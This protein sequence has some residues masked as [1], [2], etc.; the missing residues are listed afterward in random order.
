MS[1]IQ[2][3]SE[4]LSGHMS[5]ELTT[6]GLTIAKECASSGLHTFVNSH[7]GPAG[8]LQRN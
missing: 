8:G 4:A 6:S 2:V 5:P 3:I 1:L 7:L